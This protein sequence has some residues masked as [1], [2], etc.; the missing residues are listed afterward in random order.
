M[1]R[2]ELRFLDDSLAVEAQF[3]PAL[4]KPNDLLE[5][6]G[7]IFRMLDAP[8][9]W[10]KLDH[11]RNADGEEEI[12]FLAVC[13]VEE[14]E[15]ERLPRRGVRAV[16]AAPKPVTPPPAVESPEPP[17]VTPKRRGRRRKAVVDVTPPSAALPESEPEPEFID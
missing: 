7:R 9:L 13:R 16:A 5:H 10:R 11:R 12:D 15:T 4:M 2:A 6:G 14:I 1:I 8:I 3:L 17:E